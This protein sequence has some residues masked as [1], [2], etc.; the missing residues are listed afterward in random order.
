METF[1]SILSKSQVKT[2][3]H[4]ATLFR[5]FFVAEEMNLFQR[6]F[7][8]DNPT[9]MP[10]M[11][12]TPPKTNII[13]QRTYGT[14]KQ[15]FPFKMVSFS[16]DIPSFLLGAKEMKCVRQFIQGLALASRSILNHWSGIFTKWQTSCRESSPWWLAICIF[17]VYGFE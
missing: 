8:S 14:W 9:L 4:V 3:K 15:T 2:F 16:G 17:K 7:G 5:D 10:A 12:V 11:K 13:H 1:L 6:S